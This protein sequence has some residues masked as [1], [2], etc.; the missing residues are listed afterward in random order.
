MGVHNRN[1]QYG[2]ASVKPRDAEVVNGKFNKKK[3]FSIIGII[4]AILLIGWGATAF[5]K[6]DMDTKVKDSVSEMFKKDESKEMDEN[7]IKGDELSVSEIMESEKGINKAFYS[8]NQQVKLAIFANPDLFDYKNEPRLGCDAMLFVNKE[9]KRTPKILNATLEALFND[10]FDYGF[11][12]ANF[13]SKQSNLKFDYAVIENAV[14]KVFLSGQLTIT[15]ENCDSKRV[16]Y[17]IQETAKQ[18]PTVK[19]VEIFL[20][21]VKMEL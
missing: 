1:K 20:N 19:S 12:P 5:F 2:F 6:S 11:P 15:N 10:T 17:Q 4:V 16:I 21:G 8:P 18:F 13:V 3:V 7:K 14:A 9:V